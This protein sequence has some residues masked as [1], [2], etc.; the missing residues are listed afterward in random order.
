MS[1][2]DQDFVKDGYLTLIFC[3][4]GPF[5]G[6]VFSYL[7]YKQTAEIILDPN[8][9]A[10]SGKAALIINEDINS[11]QAAKIWEV[12]NLIYDGA[13]SFLFA[14]YRY[15]GIFVAIFSVIILVV[16]GATAGGKAPW[17]DA[18][19]TVIAFI[20]G[21][22]T[23]GMFFLFCFILVSRA[24]CNKAIHKEK[25]TRDLEACF[26]FSPHCFYFSFVGSISHI[27]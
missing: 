11:K 6:F 1:I 3:L 17:V 13:H 23:S 9:L 21:C 16:L 19:F 24:S 26:G 27:E 14:E 4:V 10:E 18:I 2:A 5:L 25:Q 22:A 12:Y 8:R 7:Y 15:I 20:V